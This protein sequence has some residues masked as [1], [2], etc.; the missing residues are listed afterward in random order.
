MIAPPMHESNPGA[1]PGAP[2]DAGRRLVEASAP[3]PPSDYNFARDVLHV[4]AV[5]SPD[6]LAVLGIAADGSLS[7]WTYARMA[8]ASARL[9]A[10]MQ[11]AGLV[12]G[13]RV[14]MFMARTPLWQVGM[15]ACLHLGLIPVPCVT[16][17][18]ESEL[19]YRVTQCGARGALASTELV[20]RF[21]NAGAGL[22][23]R[24]ASSGAAGWADIGAIIDQP[25]PAPPFAS[26]PAD[27]PALIYFTSGSSGLPKPVVHAARGVFVR[28]WQPWRQLGMGEGDLIWTTSDTGWTRA[29]SCLLFGPWSQGA[30]ALIV[31]GAISLEDRL[32]ILAERGVTIYGAVATELRQLLAS[33]PARS[34]PK[35]RWTL[36]AGEAMTAD[37]A[38]RWG[39]YSGAPLVVGY[40]QTETPT[41]TL[42]DPQREP[43][44]GMIGA[45]MA[46]NRVTVINEQGDE[47]PPGEEG[48]LVFS[49]ADPG[50]LLGYWADGAVV[51]SP[52]LG[53]W[54]L[55][56]DRGWRDAR[57]ELFF[58]G[59]SDDVISSAGYR[60]G[61][62]EV[63]NALTQHPSVAEC[64]VAASPDA[65]RT[66]VVKAFVVLQPGWSGG[67]ALVA[68]LQDHVKRLIAPYKYPRKLEFVTSLPR[69][70]SGKV[71]RRLL[72]QA[73]F[74]GK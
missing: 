3:Q 60:I 26:M 72:R 20:R 55:T 39:D 43:L 4:R 65:Q 9:A 53:G 30:A 56:G 28:G 5:K 7:R 45:P 58:I 1:L 68:E 25:L 14:I 6:A 19:A 15:S 44:N 69:T 11:A 51:A 61:P 16:Q 62:T 57:G 10:A 70:S 66:E 27:A 52:R 54:H 2:A 8:E 48:E 12:A 17:I 37:L 73:E 63:E 24:G 34:L 71:S 49:L 42:T 35:L 23:F 47:L 59:R 29:G 32:R 38:G 64:A 74:D 67:E 36:S 31:D 18:S 21:A 13:D 41:A 46:G 50:L 40:G 22:A 33:V